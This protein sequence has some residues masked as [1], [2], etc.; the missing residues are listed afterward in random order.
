M[1]APQILHKQLLWNALG[2]CA[3][4]QE[5]FTTIVYA[6][7]G[8]QTECIMG[9]WKIENKFY[10]FNYYIWDVK[11]AW[12]SKNR[13]WC[14]WSYHLIATGEKIKPRRSSK[15]FVHIQIHIYLSERSIGHFRVPLYLRFKT[16][17]SAKLFIWKWVLHAV[18]FSCKS[19]SFS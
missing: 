7:P 5:Y 15:P 19:K 3:Y 9:N 11:Y 10:Q 6:K 4:S 12:T 18:S 2:R 14:A 17:L 1:F 13:V 8:G 16:S